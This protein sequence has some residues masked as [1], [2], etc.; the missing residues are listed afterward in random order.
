MIRFPNAK[1]NLGLRVIGK[2]PDGY[3][4]IETV[5][6]P[7]GLADILEI[8][9]AQ[10]GIFELKHTGLVIPGEE[11]DNLC[12]RAYKDLQAVFELP[13][14]KI[15]LHKIIPMGSGLG[16]G[17]SDGA[18]TIRIL[19]DLF[20]LGLSEE[21]MMT[22]A[23]RLGSDCAFFVRNKPVYAVEKGDRF[24]TQTVDLSVFTLVIVVPPIHVNTAKAYAMLDSQGYVNSPMADLREIISG[25]AGD[26]R[27]TLVNDF[28]IPVFR[29]H[30]ELQEIKNR[31][32]DSGAV[33]VSMSGS[34]SAVYGLF[35]KRECPEVRFDDCFQWL[36]E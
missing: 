15:H 19:N 18:A 8:V 7:V 32:Y 28:E 10:D 21:D 12:A 17:S 34:G 3:H 16:G 26:W 20:R 5:F 4:D 27:S 13:P 1:I 29:A 35:R 33:Y 9:P 6:Y 22:Y 14:V 36:S 23:R 25:P 24:K 11:A 2:R 30:P 31:L